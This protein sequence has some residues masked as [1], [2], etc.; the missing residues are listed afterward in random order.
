M[1]H[2]DFVH[3]HN[4][5]EYSLL[6]GA[7]RIDDAVRVAKQYRMPALALTD[8][9]NMFGAVEFYNKAIKAGIKP[10]IGI[11]AYVAKGKMSEKAKATAG[12]NHLIL[13]AENLEGYQNLMKLASVAY[14][15]GFYYSPRIDKEVLGKYSGGIMALSSCIKGEI[16]ELIL[17]GE[18]EAATAMTSLYSDIFGKGKFYL[19]VQNHGIKEEDEA[20]RGILEIAGRTGLPVVATNDCHY[21]RREDAEAHDILLCIQT[22]KAVEDRSRLRFNTEEVYF[23]PPEEMKE[24]FRELPEAYG[25]TIEVAEKCNL[26]LKFGRPQ[27]PMYPLPASYSTHEDCLRDVAKAGMAMRFPQASGEIE[28]RV[29]FELK[30][31]CE[32]GFASYFLV[33]RD[34]IDRAR[35]EGIAVGPGRGSAAG[36]LVAYCLGITDVDPLKFGLLFERFLNPERVT[37]PDIDIDFDDERRPEII[38]YVIEKYGAESVA[39]VITFGTLK[40]RAVVRDVGRALSLPYSEVDRIAKLIPFDL[41]ITLDEATETVPALKALE[42][43]NDTMK[44]LLRCAKTLEG[45]P[46]HAS[47]HAAGVV[48]APGKLTD[49]V[50]LFKSGKDEV[51]TQYDMKSL[52]KIGLFK[53]DF[54]G[55]RTLT[56]I[57]RTVSLVRESLGTDLDLDGLGLNDRKTFE[58][59][60]KGN[61]VGV[62]QLESPG[63]RDLLRKLRCD[64]FEDIVAVNALYRPGPL[65]GAK[66]DDFIERKLKRKKTVYEHPLLEPILKDT[67]GVILYQEQVIRIANE[68]AG[69]SLGKADILRYAMGKKR[70]EEMETQEKA[71][72]DGAK[73]RGIPEATAR[74]I[75]DLMA[76]FAGYGFNKS[77]AVA[78]ALLSYRTAFLKAHYPA[79]FMAA[80]LTSEMDSSD[81]IM[82]LIDEARRMG[83][84]IL[85]PDINRSLGTFTLEEGGVRFGL[86]ATK[87]VG[88]SSVKSMV[89]ARAKDGNFT[90]LS[91]FL[92][93]ID[94]RSAN[95]RV[96]ESLLWAGAFDCFGLGRGKLE[97]LLPEAYQRAQGSQKEGTKLQA[98]L[99]VEKNGEGGSDEVEGAREWSRATLLAKEKE[100]LGFYLTEHPLAPFEEEIEI[101]MTSKIVSLKELPDGQEVSVVGVVGAVKTTTDRKGKRMAFLTL[102]DLTG[103][104]ECILFSDVYEKSK[105]ALVSDS[106]LLVRGRTSTREEEESKLLV[107][108]VVSWESFRKKLLG[109][110]HIE[111]VPEEVSKDSL[112]R[113]RKILETYPG[114]CEVLF[115]VQIESGNKVSVLGKSTKVEITSELLESLRA[116]LGNGRVRLGN[117]GEPSGNPEAKRNR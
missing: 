49:H 37:M 42:D 34:F 16:P 17:R 105:N 23:K 18:M 98:S 39:Q 108:D 84:K 6:D 45:L 48:I 44:K 64:C 55:L 103:S 81:R 106:V 72:I 63:M 59:L 77:H 60:K 111:I 73:G 70:Q 21:L 65:S 20:I 31:I 99:F 52:E 109:T 74:R 47:T 28:E 12:Q 33:V 51:T 9:G 88:L 14:L 69:F 116:V 13:L 41:G 96:V 66:I 92:R 10:I 87:N 50:P 40:A 26:E 3:L 5:T 15:E 62:F 25:R 78:Y 101:A 110:L 27:L 112:S 4:H 56:V 83:I 1:Q 107:S 91:D 68:L 22:G 117:G 2:C 94:L 11:E 61:T 46:R 102:E 97:A 43:G 71:F 115:H 100:A 29:E 32:M 30:T 54:L 90:G 86:G 89:D 93:R 58:L 79:Q 104:I 114:N 35:R 7:L 53:M 76:H 36:S 24:R 19:E 80:L 113:T 82:L 8:H 75:F 95:R 38:N 57:G 67:Y 85:P